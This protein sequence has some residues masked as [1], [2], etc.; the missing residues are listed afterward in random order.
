MED[1]TNY[2]VSLA[3]Q[4]QKLVQYLFMKASQEDWHGVRDA[5]VDIEIIEVKMEIASGTV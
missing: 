3:D 4:K 5:C 2:L 1:T